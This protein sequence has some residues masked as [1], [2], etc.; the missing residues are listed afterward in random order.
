MRLLALNALLLVALAVQVMYLA[1]VSVPAA[2][3]ARSAERPGAAQAPD[4]AVPT[5]EPLPRELVTVVEQRPLFTE[6]RRPPAPPPEPE[7]EPEPQA[8]AEQEEE[9]PPP[10]PEPL[11][12]V[13]RAIVRD[14]NGGWVLL[15]QK[16]KPGV[17]RL[18]SGDSVQGWTLETLNAESAIF[19]QRD[20]RQTLK[21]RDYD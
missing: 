19:V 13:L 14:G 18:S 4:V 8:P 20:E 10:P 7:P 21:L 6:S 12:A 15:E 9:Q 2:A 3:D 16:G 5:L 17:R 11:A 1:D